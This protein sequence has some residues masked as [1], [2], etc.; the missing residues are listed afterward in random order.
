VYRARNA[1][2][3]ADDDTVGRFSEF[4]TPRQCAERDLFLFRAVDNNGGGADEYYSPGFS[5]RDLSRYRYLAPT[6]RII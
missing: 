4:D 5:R 2:G 1:T 3:L 6:G